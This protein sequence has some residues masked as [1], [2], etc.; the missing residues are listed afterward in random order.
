MNY[1]AYS[2]ISKMKRIIKFLYKNLYWVLALFFIVYTLVPFLSPIAFHFHHPR[3]GWWIQTIYKFLCHQRPERSLFLF[4]E[5]LTYT[6]SELRD[7]G[8]TGTIVGFRFVGNDTT[9]YKVAFCIRDVFLYGGMGFSGILASTMKAKFS[10]PWWGLLLSAAPMA[11]DGLTQFASEFLYM[12]QN[13]WGIS[14]A[15]PY[16][17]SNNVTRAVT[18]ILFGVGVGF[19][20]FSELKTA[21]QETDI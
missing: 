1:G 11:I 15:K 12:T 13:S 21:I 18:G 4:G 20:I 3:V 9:G 16:Y 19:F 8:Y 6:L 7:H 10:L 17:L 2:S 5:Q 14:L